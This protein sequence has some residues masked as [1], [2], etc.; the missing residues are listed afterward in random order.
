M[1]T[2]VCGPEPT[3]AEPDRVG[4]APHPREMLSLVGHR[5]GEAEFLEAYRAGRLHH[6][7]LIGG[8]EG[9]GKATLA[10]RM[11]RFMLANP[12]PSH[13]QVQAAT[14][15]DVPASH[16]VAHQ[17]ASNAHPDLAM[18][19]RIYDP[20]KKRVL[21]E[22]SADQVRKGLDVF[23][24]TSAAGGFRI[25]IVDACDD[26]NSHSANAL[27][28]TLEEP[29]RQSL[30][31]MVAHQPLRLLP[32]IRSRCRALNLRPLSVAEVENVTAGLPDFAELDITLHQRA[33]ALSDGS[34]KQALGLLD[35]KRLDFNDK[36]EAALARLPR[37]NPEEIDAIA[38]LTAGR[39]GEVAFDRFCTLCQAWLTREL[40]RRAGQNGA[41][42]PV[43]EL[44]TRLED[45]RRDVEVYNLDKRPFVISM[46]ADFAATAR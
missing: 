24:K 18:I 23:N 32:T 5:E 9:I 33:A 40:N 46:L 38:E 17:V 39:D 45:Q 15:L 1:L 26:L 3:V 13:H 36:V 25:A 14:S 44:W 6:A 12:D 7:W 10:Y 42:M 30:F 4:S 37:I 31:L 2:V 19:R 43:A 22:I 27:L 34:V 16:P 28:K 21:T 8:P 41:L 11:A 35:P 20:E 29:P